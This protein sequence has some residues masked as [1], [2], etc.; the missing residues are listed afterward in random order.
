MNGQSRDRSLEVREHF[1]ERHHENDLIRWLRQGGEAIRPHLTTIAAV[2]A[3]LLVLW[4]YFA[5]QRASADAR[6]TAAWNEFFAE[7]YD[8]VISKYQDTDAARYARMRIASSS[9]QEGKTLLMSKRSEAVK[10]FEKA[11]QQFDTVASD[12]NASIDMR[13]SAAY[14][15]AVTLESSGAPE[16]AKE[17]Y[18]KVATQYR[19]SDEG[20][21]AERRAKELSRPSAVEFYRMLASYKPGDRPTIP[22][23]VGKSDLEDMLRGLGANNPNLPPIPTPPPS[24]SDGKNLDSKDVVPSPPPAKKAT[25][26][27]PAPGKD[28]AENDAKTKKDV[29]KPAPSK[30]AEPPKK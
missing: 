4:G 8:T 22:K 21:Q 15:K 29:P 30:P 3:A 1:E 2:V 6:R 14:L 11:E 27:V 10:A 26:P 5:W 20:R 24:K 7:D 17:Q 18:S 28:L 13:R 23:P 19:D 16:K 25:T 9:L 12:S